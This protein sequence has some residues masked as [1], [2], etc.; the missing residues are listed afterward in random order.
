LVSRDLTG[1]DLEGGCKSCKQCL[2]I[3]TLLNNFPSVSVKNISKRFIA[4]TWYV[5][6]S[7]EQ[8]S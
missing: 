5:T 7:N 2:G 1:Q 3:K 4:T 6:T 8:L